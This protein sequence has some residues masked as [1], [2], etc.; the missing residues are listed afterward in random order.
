MKCLF[1]NVRGLASS[2][3]V[4]K[5]LITVN[6]PSF[7][8]IVEPWMHYKSFPTRLLARLNLNLFAVNDRDSLAPN[9]WCI[10]SN[11]LNLTFMY[12]DSQQVT[13]FINENKTQSITSIEDS[14]GK[15]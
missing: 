5:R 13:F 9:I 2:P 12:I 3:L 1:W 11:N 4:L 6:K 15:P 10:F 7:V 14:F 8:L